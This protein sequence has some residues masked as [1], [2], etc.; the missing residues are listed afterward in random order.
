MFE[1][2]GVLLG[3]VIYNGDELLT[4]VKSLP[5]TLQDPTV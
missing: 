4:A 5:D 2:P 3:N 1:A